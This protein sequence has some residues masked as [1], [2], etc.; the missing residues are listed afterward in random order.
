MFKNLIF[1]FMAINFFG[2]TTS[3]AREDIEGSKDHPMISRYEGSYIRGYEH[4]DYD[5]LTFYTKKDGN[6]EEIEPEGKAMRIL[7]FLPAEGLSVLQV[8]RNYQQALT[9][10]GFEMVY[11]CFGGKDEIPRDIYRDFDTISGDYSKNVFTG[12]DQSYFF[13]KLSQEDGDVYI[14]AHTLPGEWAVE[15]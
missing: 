13:A 6:L 14:S 11:E 5:R 7:Y 15:C 8:Q 12:K 10:G 2:F 9:D 3:Y 4:Y 1:S